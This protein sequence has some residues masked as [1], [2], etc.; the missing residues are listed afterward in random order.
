[1]LKLRESELNDIVVT[2]ING[3][4]NE[5]SLNTDDGYID[6]I[7]ETYSKSEEDMKALDY[8]I[9]QLYDI[10]QE[11]MKSLVRLVNREIEKMVNKSIKR[12]KLLK[13]KNIVNGLEI[14]N[15]KK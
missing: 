1:M 5:V 7:I 14:E 6:L 10:V 12:I 15:K 11:D 4:F 2:Y 8:L 3:L 13:L 9:S